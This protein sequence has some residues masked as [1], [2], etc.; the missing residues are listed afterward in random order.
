[1]APSFRNAE[2]L[3]DQHNPEFTMLEYYTVDADSADSLLITTD[4][5]RELG[6]T[7]EPLVISMAECWHRWTGIDL[8]AT[9]PQEG[10]S[11]ELLHEAMI[12]RGL[13]FRPPEELDEYSWEDLFHMVFL[14]HIEPHVPRDV[15]V[16]ITQYPS[17]I[18]TLAQNIPNTP[19]ADRWELY[20]DGMEVANCYGEETDPT[21]IQMFFTEQQNLKRQ[22]QRVIPPM[23]TTFLQPPSVLP[24]CSGVALG[25]ERLGMYFFEEKTINRVISFPLFR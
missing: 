4:L 3:G 21:R 22:L 12:Q 9:I 19:W 15:P 2:S 20:L 7:R 25:V 14:S 6:E 23:D 18:P 17:A 13:T 1:M 16:F 8:A 11:A 5:L 10:P 24:R